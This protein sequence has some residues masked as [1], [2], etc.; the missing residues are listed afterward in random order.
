VATDAGAT[1][2]ASSATE[3]V[4]GCRSIE[5]R[6]TA[7]AARS[8][9]VNAFRAARRAGPSSGRRRSEAMA[10]IAMPALIDIE[11]KTM[12]AGAT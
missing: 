8:D 10:L 9:P 5:R 2:T 12:T 7:A 1:I 4:G 3:A 11:M 6:D